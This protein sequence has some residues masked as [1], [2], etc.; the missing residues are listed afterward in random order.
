MSILTSKTF[1]ISK[2]E[3]FQKQN[4]WLSRNKNSENFNAKILACLVPR[5]IL[6]I[7]PGNWWNASLFRTSKREFLE[8]FGNIFC[9]W[10]HKVLESSSKTCRFQKSGFQKYIIRKRKPTEKICLEEHALK[11]LDLT[12]TQN[13]TVT[14]LLSSPQLSWLGK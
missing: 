11:V 3:G 2:T 1:R 5:P 13:N 7:Y 4:P 9:F 6:G 14:R 12:I 10:W 8:T